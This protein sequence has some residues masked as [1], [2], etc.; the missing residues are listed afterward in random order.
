[1]Y[2]DAAEI[3]GREWSDGCVYDGT[4]YKLVLTWKN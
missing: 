1:M 2:E 4:E 3:E